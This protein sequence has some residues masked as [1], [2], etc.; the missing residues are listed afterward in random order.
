MTR[1]LDRHSLIWAKRVHSNDAPSQTRS[2]SRR[3]SSLC[4]ITVVRSVN[5]MILQSTCAISA[6]RCSMSSSSRKV[7][8]P[9]VLL[10]ISMR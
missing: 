6:D 4:Q 7:S 8:H 1:R 2:S 9:S 5:K 3:V 10:S